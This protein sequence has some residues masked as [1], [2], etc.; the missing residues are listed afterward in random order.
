MWR[1]LAA[2]DI[3]NDGDIDIIA[4][5]L[6]LNCHYRIS[7]QYPVKLFAKDIDNNGSIDP[8]MFYHILTNS[9]ERKLYPAIGKDMLTSQVPAL[10]KKFVLHEQYIPTTVDD[11][12]TDKT[13]LLELT[14]E[15]AATCYS[16][17][18]EMASS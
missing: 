10:K 3:D 4:G 9:G 6:G 12:F 17:T 11:I 16:K 14:C 13:N 2:A 5:N 8:V 15:E 1:S 18:K 7:S